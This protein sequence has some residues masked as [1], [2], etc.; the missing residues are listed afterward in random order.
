LAFTF[1]L[2]CLLSS[3]FSLIQIR[4]NGVFYQARENHDEAEVQEDV[5]TLD[6]TNFRHGIV[7]GRDQS[8]HRE[9]LKISD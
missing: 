4:N 7:C 9:H 2:L 8:G 1:G 3:C 5:Q 6:I